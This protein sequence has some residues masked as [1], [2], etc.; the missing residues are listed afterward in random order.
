[1]TSLRVLLADTPSPEHEVAWALFDSA[2]A[3]TGSG[4]A[5]P[6]ALPRADRFEAVVAASRVRIAVIA[7]PPMPA[8]RLANAARFALEDQLADPSEAQQLA[9]SIQQP[10]GSVRAVVVDRALLQAIALGEALPQPARIV[11]EPDLAAAG[12]EW[13]WCASEGRDGFVRCPDGSAFPVDAPGGDGALPSELAL[14]LGQ[15]TRS[16]TALVRVLV[17]APFADALLARW[18][19]ETGV[20]FRLG[21]PWHWH[22]VSPEALSA[23]ID[24]LP[25]ARAP[26]PTYSRPGHVRLFARALW[27]AAAA[28][29]LH[30]L[31]TTGEWAWLK[32]DGWREAREWTV[33]AVSAGVTPEAAATPSSARAALS[34]RHA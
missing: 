22:A 29:A 7:L 15:A 3:C 10:D 33:L 12:S 17:D 9:L 8:S 31:A 32:L 19:R 6:P 26:A 5:R 28:L 2:G 14:A 18:Q 20:I 25:G 23:A 16:G 21:K 4:R 11:A 30:I 13:R 1:M 34:R 27:I 24:L